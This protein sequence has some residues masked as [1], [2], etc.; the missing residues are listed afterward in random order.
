MQ[1]AHGLNVRRGVSS[2]SPDDLSGDDL[3]VIRQVWDDYGG[4]N[5]DELVYDV[6]HKLP[7]WTEHWNAEGRKSLSVKVPNSNL[8]Q[9][10]CGVDE[11]EARYLAEE[12]RDARD[13]WIGSRP[14]KSS[15]ARQ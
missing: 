11:T 7:E 6:H 8:Y 2:G 3:Q 4:M 12:Y 14:G 5:Q 15:A 1:T 9:S 13:R 10:V